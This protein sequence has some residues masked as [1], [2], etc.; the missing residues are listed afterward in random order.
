MYS[1]EN[2][3]DYDCFTRALQTKVNDGSKHYKPLGAVDLVPYCLQ[4]RLPN[5]I[6]RRGKQTL[7]VVTWN[8][9]N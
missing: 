5:N 7:K 3:V 8:K 9:S 6:S 2:G 4:Y 1:L